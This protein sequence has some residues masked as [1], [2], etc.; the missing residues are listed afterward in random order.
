[1]CMCK[2]KVAKT[3]KQLVKK[4]TKNR[5]KRGNSDKLVQRLKY[6]KMYKNKHKKST[7]KGH[8]FPKGSLE[9]WKEAAH[10]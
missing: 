7:Y 1:M 2:K 8:K 3:T 5:K 9:L 4:T 10:S 6:Y